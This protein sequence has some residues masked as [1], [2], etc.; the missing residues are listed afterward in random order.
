MNKNDITKINIPSHL[1]DSFD[2]F[3]AVAIC[4]LDETT[5][6]KDWSDDEREIVE[7]LESGK[8]KPN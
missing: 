4:S 5:E 2:D 1:I 6:R 3:I 8:W 7:W